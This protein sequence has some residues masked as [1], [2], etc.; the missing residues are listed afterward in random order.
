MKIL[1]VGGMHGNE[2]LGINLVKEIRLRPIA[3][4]DVLLA[5]QQAV[6]KNVRFVA[7]DLNRSFPGDEKSKLYE[8]K[9]A[10]ELICASKL[11]DLVLDFHNTGFANND[12]GFVGVDG[13]SKLY[14]VAGAV[15]L[16]RVIVAD[17][18]CINKFVTNCLSVEIS[19][20]SIQNNVALWYEKIAML[21]RIE[22][23]TTSL[24]IEKYK[25]VYRMT[26]DDKETYQLNP[27]DFAAFQP[28]DRELADN[29]GVDSP[30]YPIFVSDRFTPY[31]FGGLLNRIH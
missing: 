14:D 8:D 12:C 1:V 30:A 15:G 11:Y 22:S 16:A 23:L 29:L 28:V 27:K 25:F 19:V 3:N 17:Y 20:D 7:K 24:V 5:N 31:N 4:V 10:A 9:R 26:L 6:A 13:V 21:A 2:M 18:D